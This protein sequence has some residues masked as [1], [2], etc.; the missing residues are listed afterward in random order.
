MKKLLSLLFICSTATVPALVH[1]QWQVTVT[2]GVS[3]NKQMA[4]K[5][6]AGQPWYEKSSSGTLSGSQALIGTAGASHSISIGSYVPN[7]LFPYYNS[8]LNHAVQTYAPMNAYVDWVGTGPVPSSVHIRVVGTANANFHRAVLG[9]GLV[10]LRDPIGGQGS[11]S[12]WTNADGSISGSGYS[13]SVLE[14]D[15]PTYGN[16]RALEASY[17]VNV[18]SE[19]RLYS[20]STVAMEDGDP[21]V[22]ATWGLT[23]TAS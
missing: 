17:Y 13:S 5:D 14:W 3:W 10:T 21:K 1:A 6:G 23:V 19:A 8:S 7:F 16:T 2:K 12:Y 9:T 4:Y 20:D 18:Q 22:D 15:Q 11:W